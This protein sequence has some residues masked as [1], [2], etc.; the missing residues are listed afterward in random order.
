L[1]L[2]SVC[3]DLDKIVNLGKN[4]KSSSHLAYLHDYL[5]LYRRVIGERGDADFSA[6]ML[7]AVTPNLDEEIGGSVN[8]L[9]HLGP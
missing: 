9:R 1:G 6:R 4:C 3:G 8:H 7:P 5:G 2:Y